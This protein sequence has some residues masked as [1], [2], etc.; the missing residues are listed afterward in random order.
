MSISN[1]AILHENHSVIVQKNILQSK[2]WRSQPDYLVQ[3]LVL[4]H[5]ADIIVERAIKR[6]LE[7]GLSFFAYDVLFLAFWLIPLP[8]STQHSHG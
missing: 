6:F 1:H 3:Q 7:T 8:L 2:Q 4:V 5:I